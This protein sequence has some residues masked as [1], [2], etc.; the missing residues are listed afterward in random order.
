[1]KIWIYRP[2]MAKIRLDCLYTPKGKQY[3]EAKERE[4]ELKEKIEEAEDFIRWQ[5]KNKNKGC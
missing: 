2:D 5:K 4:K 1:M 3:W